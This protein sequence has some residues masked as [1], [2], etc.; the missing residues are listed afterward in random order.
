MKTNKTVF[1]QIKFFTAKTKMTNLVKHA[2]FSRK[3]LV[4]RKSNHFRNSRNDYGVMVVMKRSKI[5]Q[6]ENDRKYS[7]KTFITVCHRVDSFYGLRVN[8][9]NQS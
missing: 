4:L 8:V 7:A 3:G 5:I 1:V 9:I 2:I 6:D